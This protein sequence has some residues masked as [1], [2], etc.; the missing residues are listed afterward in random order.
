MIIFGLIHLK[1][2]LKQE[3]EVHT[4]PFVTQCF[5]MTYEPLLNLVRVHELW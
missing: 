5:H 4:I 2:G 3:L 1:L